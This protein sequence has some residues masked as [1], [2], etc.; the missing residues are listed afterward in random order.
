MPIGDMPGE[1]VH[2]K[3]RRYLDLLESRR[4]LLDARS[5]AYGCCD[6]CGVALEVAALEEM[7]WAD[8]CASHPITAAA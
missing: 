6:V 3:L 5:E 1:R 4:R 2:E 8:R 7:P